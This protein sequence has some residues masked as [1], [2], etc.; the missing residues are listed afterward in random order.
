M[1]SDQQPE[2]IKFS[3]IPPEFYSD[4][5]GEPFDSCVNCGK[6]LLIPGT[7]Y[8]IEK[9]IVQTQPHQTKNTI[10]EYAMCFDCWE[11]TK[12]SLSA[13]SLQNIQEYFAQRVDFK[14]RISDLK[15]EESM[16]KW[17]GSCI[18]KGK[19]RSEL[20]EYQ[21]ACQCDGPYM[22]YHFLPYL[23]S[24]EVMEELMELLSE[25]TLGEMD[26]FKKKLTAPDPDLEELFDKKKILMV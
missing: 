24:G 3:A 10:F 7:L 21:I 23:I 14:N 15:E 17:L 25:Q 20:K 22:A 9:A 6:N 5:T 19:D 16:D 1:M 26:N 2:H 18:V 8:I 12:K 13:E 11:E 4:L